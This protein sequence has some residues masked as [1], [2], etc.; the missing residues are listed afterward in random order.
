[1]FP[2]IQAHAE[3]LGED[4]VVV[5]VLVPVFEVQRV[6]IPPMGGAVFLAGLLVLPAGKVEGDGE[7]VQYQGHHHEFQGVGR[8]SDVKGAF[9][10]DT[11]TPH[12][13]ENSHVLPVA[14]GQGRPHPEDG[15]GQ[16]EPREGSAVILLLHGYLLICVSA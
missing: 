12:Q 16:Q 5:G 4:H 1:M 14:A 10:Y 7:G 13:V 8:P 3:I 6:D 11:E 9:Q 2:P 15:D